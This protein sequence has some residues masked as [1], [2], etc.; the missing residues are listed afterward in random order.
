MRDLF[1]LPFY[2]CKIY[3]KSALLNKSLTK[4]VNIY[5]KMYKYT[6]SNIETHFYNS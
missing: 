4:Y 3:L 6:L 5:E 2:Y 1:I